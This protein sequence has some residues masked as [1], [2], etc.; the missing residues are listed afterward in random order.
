MYAK[1]NISG[2]HALYMMIIMGT[3][4]MKV[5]CVRAG[6]RRK[7]IILV[8]MNISDRT[9]ELHVETCFYVWMS[10]TCVVLIVAIYVTQN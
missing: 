6:G 5:V 9:I 3:M 2:R 4:F 7:S 10:V 1:T 8:I